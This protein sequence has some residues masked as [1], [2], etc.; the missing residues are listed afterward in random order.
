MSIEITGKIIAVL[1]M[2]EGYSRAGKLWRSQTYV[3]EADGQYPKKVAFEVKGD[4]IAQFGLRIGETYNLALDID[5]REYNGRWF[6]T[7]TAFQMHS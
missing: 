3:L 6:N 1:P 4:R 5:A 7:I 2:R